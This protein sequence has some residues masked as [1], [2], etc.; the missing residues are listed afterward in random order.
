MENTP[1]I[2]W[3]FGGSTAFNEPSFEDKIEAILK[4]SSDLAFIEA[5]EEGDLL[6][7]GALADRTNQTFHSPIEKLEGLF[8]TAK[9]KKIS[10][11]VVCENLRC[12]FKKFKRPLRL[13]GSQVLLFQNNVFVPLY[14]ENQEWLTA[15]KAYQAIRKITRNDF[16]HYE[17]PKCV[18]IKIQSALHTI[19]H[20]AF[21]QKAYSGKSYYCL[22]ASGYIF[23]ADSELVE[24][25]EVEINYEKK[26]TTYSD[27]F[28][29]Y[30]N[31]GGNSKSLRFI[32][33][34]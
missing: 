24:E 19:E 10:R 25:S 4:K 12:N 27:D 30:K 26:S 9:L 20:L 13:V 11:L 34:K 8:V 17:G 33:N 3:N 18:K 2:N 22:L 23:E 7:V 1:L 5:M 14:A 16:G 28:A 32:E 29:Q 21:V 6:H 15:E 31:I